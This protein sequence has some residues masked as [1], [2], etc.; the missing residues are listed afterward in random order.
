MVDG[1]EASLRPVTYLKG[2]TVCRVSGH[3]QISPSVSADS[4]SNLTV[5]HTERQSHRDDERGEQ[6]VRKLTL[7]GLQPPPVAEHGQQDPVTA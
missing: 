5:S 1:G 6:D 4:D 7:H 3:A 2:S